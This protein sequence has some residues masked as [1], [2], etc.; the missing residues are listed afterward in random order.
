VANTF[1]ED[2]TWHVRGIS[3]NPG[4][5]AC[6]KLISKGAEI[7]SG[8]TLSKEFLITAFKGAHIIFATTDFWSIYR[9]PSSRS[10]LAK[11]QTLNE[12]SFDVEVQQGKNIAEAAALIVDTTL[13]LFIWSDLVG[14][15]EISG[16]KWTWVFHFDSKAQVERHIKENLPALSSKTSYFIPGGYVSNLEIFWKPVKVRNLH[17]AQMYAY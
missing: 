5:P 15:R 17:E 14:A 3:R 2:P 13:E 16:D 10:L 1:L 9:D 8:S 11:G 12:Y 7:L 6:Q 4:S